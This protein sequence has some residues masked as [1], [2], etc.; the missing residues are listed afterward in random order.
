MNIKT[1]HLTSRWLNLFDNRM[2]K[3]FVNKNVLDIGC[4]DGYSTNQF[5]KYNAKSAVGID[6]DERYIAKAIKKYP[7]IIFKLEDAEKINNFEGLDTI[8]CLGLIYF[9]KDPIKF[10]KTISMQ[11]KANTVIIETVN[12]NYEIYRD[13]N[14]CFL[15][16]DTIKKIFLDNEWKVSYNEVYN[17]KELT[18]SIFSNNINF[19]DRVILVFERQL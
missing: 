19:V 10:L 3:F 17:M 7:D 1:D 18:N 2:H 16:V 6:I 4:L 9:L 15:N 12:N 11:K 8:S 5:I 13:K 14:F